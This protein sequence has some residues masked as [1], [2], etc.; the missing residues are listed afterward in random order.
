MQNIHSGNGFNLGNMRA[1]YMKN[2]LCFFTFAMLL[3]GCASRH[4]IIGDLYAPTATDEQERVYVVPEETCTKILYRTF[5]MDYQPE[6]PFR[7]YKAENAPLYAVWRMTGLPQNQA[8][9]G[10]VFYKTHELGNQSQ[11]ALAD[12]AGASIRRAIENSG[13]SIIDYRVEKIE[14]QDEP[15]I[16]AVCIYHNRAK[17]SYSMQTTIAFFCPADAEHFIYYISWFQRGTQETYNDP[18]MTAAGETFFTLFNL[19]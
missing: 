18:Q 6:L 13:I 9:F 2:I 17:T 4:L 11:D 10:T 5:Y 16:K 3:S 19:R 8:A 15:A 12:Y 14:F 1:F 7:I